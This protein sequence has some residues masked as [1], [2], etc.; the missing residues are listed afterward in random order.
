MKY[1]FF[2]LLVGCIPSKKTTSSSPGIRLS[3]WNNEPIRIDTMTESILRDANISMP[4]EGVLPLS[5]DTTNL[6]SFNTMYEA[7]KHTPCKHIWVK[8]VNPSDRG[9]FEGTEI[10]CVKCF[11]IGNIQPQ[12]YVSPTI[13]GSVVPYTVP[14]IRTLIH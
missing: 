7:V 9:F 10:V 8:T 6:I 5:I 12:I 11:K 13:T 4:S 2:L 3:Y 14:S 1:L